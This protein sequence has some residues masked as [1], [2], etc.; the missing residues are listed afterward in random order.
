MRTVL[1]HFEIRRLLLHFLL[2]VAWRPYN[3]L[4]QRLRAFLGSIKLLPF[5]GH[6][7][8]IMCKR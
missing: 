7:K 2:E 6:L 8:G 4:L 5:G 1:D 3:Y